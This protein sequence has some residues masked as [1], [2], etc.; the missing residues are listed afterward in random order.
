MHLNAGGRDQADVL[1]RWLSGRAADAPPSGQRP[2]ALYSSPLE[3]ATETAE[4]LGRALDL[5]VVVE[6]GLNELDFG[7]WT[8]RS[9]SELDGDPVWRSF[10]SARERTRIPGGELMAEAVD[11]AVEA[12]S[13]MERAHPEGLIA[14]V[15]HG[16]II[17]GVLLRTL[18]LSLDEIHRIEVAPASV[19]TL[20][21]WNGTPGRVLSINWRPE[22]PIG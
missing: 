18:R 1:A 10:N 5:P 4:V 17:R 3:R 19:S 12:I 21:T 6:P 2:Q 11:R 9:L 16:D 22:G 13:R 20:E 14:A 8:G 15:S 7:A